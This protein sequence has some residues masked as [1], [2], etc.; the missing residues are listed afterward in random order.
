MVA[1]TARVS[2]WGNPVGALVWDDERRIGSFEYFPEFIGGGLE[3][4]PLTMPLSAG[5]IYTFPGLNPDV[6]KGLPACLSDSLP[7]DFGN[8]LIDAW[9]A[10]EGR[11]KA[12]F[13]SVERL[14]YT[15]HRAMGA[16]EYDPAINGGSRQ[17]VPVELESLVK[18]AG[19]VLSDRES[20]TARLSG[21]S[22]SPQER[23][24]MHRL[25]QIGTSAGGARPKA[26]IAMNERGD[27]RS[28]QV[29]A[30]EGF[31]HWL[32]KFDVD[33]GAS[34]LGDPLGFGRIEYAYSEL[35][36][37]AGIDMTECRLIQENERA[38]FCTRRFDR[39]DEGEK[40]HVQ[41]L[42]ALAHADFTK[43]G[44]FS[45]EE[46]FQVLRRLK[47]ARADA[48]EFYRRMVFNV[49]G[50]NNDDHTKN[51][52]ASM[53]Q[54]GEWVLSPAYDVAWS[55]RADSP[56]VSSH[57]MSINGKREGF[58]LADLRE[59]AKQIGR[60]NPEPVIE[61]VREAIKLWPEHAAAAGVREEVIFGI[62]RTQLLDLKAR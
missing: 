50:C 22:T 58:T 43:P 49:M 31:T 24:A 9:L 17:S 6:Y 30:P 60:F 57:Q 29:P 52:S 7:D 14:L 47:L 48:I 20:F 10:R 8:A 35:V 3:I 54:T 40:F 37:L 11:D 41:T 46:G 56:W 1:N 62:S 16:L 12:S 23:D 13:S 5:T 27:I 53:D 59:V 38:H 61:Q 45:Y 15:G 21:G 19:E 25:F 26:V 33:K 44:A 42:C 39:T 2:L 28:G 34:S 51:F 4:A 18:L 32:L 36:K 55:Y